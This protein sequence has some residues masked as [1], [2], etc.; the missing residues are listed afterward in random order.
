MRVLVLEDNFTQQ[1][2]IEKLLLTAIRQ[3]K[4]S[5]S[6]LELFAKSKR[7]LDC[8]ETD[9]WG[10]VYFLKLDSSLQGLV[11]AKKIR[12][13][14]LFAPIV[15]FSQTTAY[16]ASVFES[17]VRAL[18]YVDISVD[19]DCLLDR[20]ISVIDT[21]TNRY[22]FISSD[23]FVFKNNQSVLQVPK[24]Q[25]LY[26]ATSSKPHRVELHLKD[27][28][29]ELEAPLSEILSEDRQFFRCHR[30]YLIN[31][32]QIQSIDWQNRLVHF[33]NSGQ[34][35]VSRSHVQE[36]KERLSNR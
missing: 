29:V 7:V 13:H 27:R 33:S 4:G 3:S 2:R 16:M 5:L 8:C 11:I 18:D 36:L 31:L 30:S 21:I 1:L 20:L 10:T 22:S 12:Q 34:C 9:R 6:H 28:I 24:S 17:H 23:L 15:F 25:I 32:A 35:D 26:V 14:D 19:D